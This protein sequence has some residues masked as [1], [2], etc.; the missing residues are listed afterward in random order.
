MYYICDRTEKLYRSAG[1]A[2]PSP[3]R[4][5][6]RRSPSRLSQGK[7]NGLCGGVP[8]DGENYSDLKEA[9]EK[10]QLNDASLTYEH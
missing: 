10:L 2:T 4:Q 5:S 1:L 8:V 3:C 9:L 6:Q 7:A